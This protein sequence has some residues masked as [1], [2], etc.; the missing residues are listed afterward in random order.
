MLLLLLVLLLS[1][2]EGKEGVERWKELREEEEE[3]CCCCQ[4][5]LLFGLARGD[6]DADP[7]SSDPVVVTAVSVSPAALVIA[8]VVVTWLSQKLSEQ[9]SASASASWSKRSNNV[10]LL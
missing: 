1:L 5:V 7:D 9:Q 4:L 10:L 2:R 8:G 3:C 6:P